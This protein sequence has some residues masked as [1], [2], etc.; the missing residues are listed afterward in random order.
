[1]NPS[2]IAP[3][4][5]NIIYMRSMIIKNDAVLELRLDNHVIYSKKERYIQPSQM[6][7]L[8]INPKDFYGLD[9]NPDSVLEFSLN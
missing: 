3:G 4:R 1:V 9:F 6:I 8:K 5:E 2:W 7:S